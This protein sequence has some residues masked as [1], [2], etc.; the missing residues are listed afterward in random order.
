MGWTNCIKHGGHT[1][2]ITSPAIEDA[3]ENETSI[4]ISQLC[5]LYIRVTDITP[6]ARY[7]FD[8]SFL[9]K[10]GIKEAE[11]FTILTDD[12]YENL[13]GK[14]LFDS[15]ANPCKACLE[16]FCER[17]GF[18]WEMSTQGENI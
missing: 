12:G 9:E 7:V 17:I 3:I 10:L 5:F 4:A 2:T 16:D 8:K 14:L 11:K 18:K 1:I 6:Y 15:T 13:R